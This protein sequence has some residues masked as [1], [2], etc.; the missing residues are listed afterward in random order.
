MSA[1]AYIPIPEAANEGNKSNNASKVRQQNKC[2]Q[3]TEGG[4]ERFA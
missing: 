3:N 1:D 4:G 2:S